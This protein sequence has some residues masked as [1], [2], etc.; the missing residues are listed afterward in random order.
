MKHEGYKIRDQHG[1]Y[2]ITFATV[3]WVD[4]FTRY[5]YAETVLASLR[6]CIQEKGLNV[7]AWCLMSNHIH[8]IVSAKNGNV[9]DVLRDFKKYTSA[10]ILKQI[11]SNNEE[12]RKHWML[13]IFKQA[14]SNNSRNNKYQFWQ[15]DNQPI[16]LETV[17]FTLTKL[18][19]IHNNPVK[20]GMVEKPEDYLLSS[21][22]DYNSRKG[23]LVIEHLTAAYTLHKAY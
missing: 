9:S 3:Q 10:T 21:A 12:S 18:E 13:W 20:A 19:Y 2:F 17:K 23:L 8:L 4:V 5:C 1:L 7:H 6:F 11:E 16:Q 15:Q 14:G 22:R